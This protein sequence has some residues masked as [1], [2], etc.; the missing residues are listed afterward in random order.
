[1]HLTLYTD[2]SL[3]LLLFLAIQPE[4]ATITEVAERYGISRN[5]L[6]RIVHDLGKKGWIATERGRGGGI[7]LAK[8]PGEINLGSVVRDME[9][10]QIV[11]C[12]N[13]ISNTCVIA[14][15][16]LM[17]KVLADAAEAFLAELEKYT[18]ADLIKNKKMLSK[19]LIELAS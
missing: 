3:R 13:A 11:E 8:D 6:V 7:K 1:M 2:Y 15:S 9:P 4:G 10:F 12:F 5:H 16:C 19:H 17:K 18:L 14:P